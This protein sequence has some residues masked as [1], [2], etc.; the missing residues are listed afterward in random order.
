MCSSDL[1]IQ[2]IKADNYL[3]DL[4]YK[5]NPFNQKVNLNEVAAASLNT[6]GL[7]IISLIFA[8]I[9]RNLIFRKV[10][11]KDYIPEAGEMRLDPSE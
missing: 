7:I 3:D 11:K 2:L 10:A 6:L 9:I 8:V 5:I 1:F 4:F